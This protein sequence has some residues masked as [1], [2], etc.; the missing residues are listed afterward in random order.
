MICTQEDDFIFEKPRWIAV[1][2]DGTKV[3]QDD[4]RPNLEINSAWIRLKK[5]ITTTGL[6]ITK[7]YFQFRSNF[8]EPF[9][10]NAQGYYFSNGVIGQL[11]SDYSINLF[12]SGEIIGNL[13]RIKSIKVPELI[14]INEENR[15]LE[16]LS[17]DP[18][19]MND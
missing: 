17:I 1:L 2:S 4:D 14:V 10:E 5:H 3:Y 16:N 18:V 12:V 15:I 6:K 7:L 9:P 19:I 8:F 11:S 13:A